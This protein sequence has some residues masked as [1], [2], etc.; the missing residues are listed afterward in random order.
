M[1]NESSRCCRIC[2]GNFPLERFPRYKNTS[3][4]GYRYRQY[5]KDCDKARKAKWRAGRLD[6]HNAK[7]LEWVRNNPDK[8]KISS[9]KWR[10]RNPDKCRELKARWLSKNK[11]IALSY[12]SNRRRRVRNATPKWVTDTD[13]CVMRSMYLEC[14]RISSESGVPHHVDHVIPLKGKNVC[15]LHVPYNLRIIPKHDNLMKSNHF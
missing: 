6:K 4:I 10:D 5:C 2:N 12:T 15:G 13:M 1:E 9:K 11:D 14:R 8:R 7:G 3:F